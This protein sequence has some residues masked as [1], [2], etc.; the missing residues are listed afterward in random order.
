VQQ[1]LALRQRAGQIK[2]LKFQ[3]DAAL[4][5]RQYDVAIS[6]IE[7]ALRLDPSSSELAEMLESVRRKKQARE[8]IEGYLQQADGA[9]TR[10]DL[11][12]AQAII[13]KA[14]DLDKEDSRVRAAYAAVGAAGGG[15]GAA[16]KDAGVAG[17]RTPARWEAGILPRR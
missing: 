11:E 4:H 8:R 6:Q 12:A 7:E 3:A 16:G 13:A 15:G 14:L 17:F 1:N 9:R 5:E 2:E 10:G